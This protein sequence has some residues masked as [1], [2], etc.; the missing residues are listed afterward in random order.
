MHSTLNDTSIRRFLGNPFFLSKNNSS[1]DLKAIFSNNFQK[2]KD[3]KKCLFLGG[4]NVQ[5]CA[6]TVLFCSK[7]Y[8][9]PKSTDSSTRE[10]NNLLNTSQGM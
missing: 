10:R 1:N 6:V 7:L 8:C 3:I 2:L 9:F 5:Y 4:C